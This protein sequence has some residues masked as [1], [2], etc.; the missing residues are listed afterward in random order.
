VD[1]TVLHGIDRTCEAVQVKVFFKNRHSPSS[2]LMGNSQLLDSVRDFGLREL[3][4]PP[5]FALG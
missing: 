1:A 4:Q 3:K 2:L 5:G